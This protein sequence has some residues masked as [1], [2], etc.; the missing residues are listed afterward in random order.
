MEKGKLEKL[1]TLEVLTS[2]TRKKYY[3]DNRGQVDVSEILQRIFDETAE[4]SANSDGGASY[5]FSQG[6]YFVNAPL[7]VQH[8]SVK[9]S[10]SGHSGIDIHGINIAG[11]TCFYFGPAC[12]PACMTFSGGGVKKAFPSN[13]KPWD[14]QCARIEIEN[15]TFAGHNNTDVD[16]ARGYSRM[17]GD[18]PDFRSL[19]WYPQTCRYD[20]IQRDGQRG[21]V[22]SRN[23]KKCKPEMLRVTNCCFTDLYVGIDIEICDVTQISH[24]WFAQMVYGVVSHGLGQATNVSDCCFADLETALS[25]KN[26]S[27]SNLH[28]NSFAYVSKCFCLGEVSHSSITGN[29]LNN[30]KASTAAASCG[31]FCQIKGPA[32]NITITANSI[33]QE[34]DSRTKAL[35][36]DPEPDGTS[37]IHFNECSNLL[38]SNNV[39]DTLISND[40]IK[41]THSKN[42]KF[43]NNIINNGPGG[44]MINCEDNC[45]NICCRNNDNFG[46]TQE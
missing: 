6:I 5:I 28:H 14:L 7:K 10:G 36:I 24:S 39:V 19:K 31:A 35:T 21:I 33:F 45:S 4:L 23:S 9:I 43:S 44:N 20:D 30:W 38:F 26:I 13:E 25:L 3:V 16:T 15:I 42:C 8:A 1:Y 17:K 12:F 46:N 22:L 34:H 41:I 27:M 32:K 29:V 40:V 2:S 37:F 11:G 18:L